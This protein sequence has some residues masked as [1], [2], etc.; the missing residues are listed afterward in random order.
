MGTC[1]LATAFLVR[2]G[3]RVV[4]DG[5]RG[6]LGANLI[7]LLITSATFGL[8]TSPASLGLRSG[9]RAAIPGLLNSGEKGIMAGSHLWQQAPARGLAATPDLA[10]FFG[11]RLA[12]DRC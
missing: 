8:V 6:S 7:D 9:G 4:E 5:F 2:S 10:G 3:E 12:D 1:A 11:G